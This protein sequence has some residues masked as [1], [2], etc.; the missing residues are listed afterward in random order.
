MTTSWTPKD[1][2]E[3][4]VVP[5]PRLV[6]RNGYVRV[7]EDLIE[8]PIAKPARKIGWGDCHHPEGKECCNCR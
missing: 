8:V 7:R 4:P 3:Q 2:N 6:I 1:L 5:E